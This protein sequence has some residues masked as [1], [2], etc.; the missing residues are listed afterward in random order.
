[1]SRELGYDKSLISISGKVGGKA[2]FDG[3]HGFTDLVEYVLEEHY[4]QEEYDDMALGDIKELEMRIIFKL[5]PAFIQRKERP[6]AEYARRR[7]S[8]ILKTNP[9][10]TFICSK[11][12]KSTRDFDLHHIIPI[13]MYGVGGADNIAL[14]CKECHE[15][16][17][18]SNEQ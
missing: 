12:G 11:C 13:S 5:L 1:M 6:Y 16:I 3:I 9:E 10:A 4:T 17:H 18:Y 7:Y 14:L 8:K 2:L 15:Q